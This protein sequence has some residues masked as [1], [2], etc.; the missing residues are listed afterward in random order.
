PIWAFHSDA[1]NITSVEYSRNMVEALRQAGATEN[2]NYTEIEGGN[3]GT[4][5]LR[6]YADESLWQ[7]L[8]SQH[9]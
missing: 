9:K 3:H 7:W 1:D 2:L 8:L 5:F 6:A 4:P